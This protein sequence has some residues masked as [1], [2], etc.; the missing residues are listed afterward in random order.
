[1]PRLSRNLIWV[2]ICLCTPSVLVAESIDPAAIETIKAVAHVTVSDGLEYDVI[3]VIHDHQRAVFHRA[4][5]DREVAQGVDGKYY[6]EYDGT[7]ETEGP[8]RYETIVL[9]HQFHAQLLQF[10]K[11]NG[12]LTEPAL[13]DRDGVQCLATTSEKD[14]TLFV[15]AETKQAVALVYA[16]ETEPDIEMTFGD[17]RQVQGIDL[18]YLV[19]IDDGE[20]VFRY[21]YGSVVFN[22]GSVASF[23][24][25]VTLLTPE[26]QLM[27]KH[28]LMMD[29]HY[30]EDPSL[31]AGAFGEQGVI[32]Y[33][34]EV[35]PTIGAETEASLTRRLMNRNH[36]R[37]DDL[38]RP[39]IRVADDGSLGWVIVQ[40]RAEGVRFDAN[41]DP[42]GPLDFTCAWIAMYEKVAGQW[43]M[44]GNVSNFKPDRK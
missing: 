8:P 13:V 20:R 31:I 38:V 6:W 30:F 36:T 3:T 26:Q 21:Q 17:W 22:E 19:I 43:K 14:Q 41:G 11:L 23:R 28:R 37:Y 34:G 39:I 2:L 5:A 24:A 9:G 16:R 1:M 25:P 4:Y 10:E 42:S 12:P 40:V 18:P 7:R 15:D 35:A 32:V 44:A 33:E 29:A 27:R